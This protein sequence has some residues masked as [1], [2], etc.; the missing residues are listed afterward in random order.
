MHCISSGWTGSSKESEERYR[1]F[2]QNFLGIAFR[3]TDGFQPVFLHGAVEE[4]T[5]YTEQEFLSGTPAWEEIIHPQDKDAVLRSREAACSDGTTFSYE[6]RIC[7]NDGNIRWLLETG[8]FVSGT[9]T[10]PGYVQGARYDITGRKVAEL[11]LI[12]LNDDLEKRVKERTKTLNDQI[13]FLQQLIDTIPSPVFYKDAGGFYLGC[14][15]AFETYS[16][17]K[18]QEIIGKSDSALLTPELA[19]IS[20]QKDRSL[21]KNGGIQ[22]YQAKYLHADLSFRDIIFKRATFRDTDGSTAGI[23]GVM[24]DIT[25]QIRAEENLAESE[26]RFREVVQDQTELIIRFVLTGRLSLPMMHSLRIFHSTNRI[27]S[28]LSSARTFTRKMRRGSGTLLKTRPQIRLITVSRYGSCFMVVR[29]DG[30]TGA[31]VPFLTRKTRSI[32]SRLL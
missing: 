27:V 31:F 3:L 2:V 1:G 16:G 23:I 8:Q 7:R 20:C 18:S 12:Q 22:V 11:A 15:A 19:E 4:I 13:Q 29:C 28:G 5:G 26:Q 17:R 21:I 25:D 9:D 6:F 30:F 24:L 32:S 14:N 10:R